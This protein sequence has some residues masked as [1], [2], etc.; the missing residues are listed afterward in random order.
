M[1]SRMTHSHLSDHCLHADEQVDMIKPRNLTGGIDHGDVSS[2][3]ALPETPSALLLSRRGLRSVHVPSDAERI[4][5][6]NLLVGKQPASRD[7]QSIRV[8][9]WPE[10]RELDCQHEVPNRCL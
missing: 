9:G 3:L 1:I 4:G 2:W 7:F 6:R 5:F 8:A 10:D